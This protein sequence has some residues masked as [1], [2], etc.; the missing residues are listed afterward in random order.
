MFIHNVYFWLENGLTDD[1]SAA[2][3]RGLQSLCQNPPVKSGYFG[4]PAAST[5]RDVVDSSYSYC[6]VL[7]FD[8]VLGHDSYQTGGDHLQFVAAHQEKWTRV[9]VYDVETK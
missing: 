5:P 9:T 3:E 6:L 8:D 1:D 2:F 7:F 4:K